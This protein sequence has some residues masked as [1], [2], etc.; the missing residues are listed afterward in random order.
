MELR[1]VLAHCGYHTD[2][3]SQESQSQHCADRGFKIVK[4]DNRVVSVLNANL[5]FEN[6]EVND[7]YCDY[8][9]NNPCKS[10]VVIFKQIRAR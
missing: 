1:A 3:N 10:S 9:R 8:S 4:L 7:Y 5:G 6:V 2:S